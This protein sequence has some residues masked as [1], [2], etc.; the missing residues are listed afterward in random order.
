MRTS[1][2]TAHQIEAS[3]RWQ[4][5]RARVGGQVRAMR[6][7]RGWS[8]RELADRVG[9]GRMVISRIER[10]E[11]R[12]DLE[13]LERIAIVFGVPLGVTLGRD[14][15]ED[16]ADAGH[17]AMQELVLRFGR[18]G[19]FTRHFELATRPAEPW[20]SA[21]I[22]L[23]SDARQA[24]IG[25][26]CWNTFGDIGAAARSST[27]KQAELEQMAVA[28]WGAASIV[29]HLW[30]VRDVARNRALVARYP[31][32]F[33]ARFPGSSRMWVQALASGGP[34]PLEPGLVWC[35]VRRGLVTEW[36]R[37]ASRAA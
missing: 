30:V 14:P 22:V 24:L 31:E 4:E 37:A 1:R 12:L 26:E 34:I 35:D 15:R 28:R 25:I 3:R 36:R 18:V 7:R 19:G 29:G 9:V 23:G 33:A 11:G 6:Q 10:G 21:D 17:L 2:R 13:L 8:Q 27:R 20:R 16:V 5:S 32:V